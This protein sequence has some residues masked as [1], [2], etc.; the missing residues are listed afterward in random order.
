MNSHLSVIH[1]LDRRMK[2]PKCIQKWVN[3][4]KFMEKNYFKIMDAIVR[5][6]AEYFKQEERE[7]TRERERVT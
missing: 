7:S 2:Q 3:F 1:H 5:S 4:E 6:R